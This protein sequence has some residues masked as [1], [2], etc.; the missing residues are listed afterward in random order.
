MK[1]LKMTRLAAYFAVALGVAACGADGGTGGSGG[2][3]GGGTSGS[4]IL[5]PTQDIVSDLLTN[6]GGAL[7]DTPLGPF[8]QCLDPTLNELLD[9]PDGLLT[10]L[11]SGIAGAD[12]AKLQAALTSGATDL[13][14]AIQSLTVNLPNA[15]LALAGEASCEQYT[16]G[17]G[18]TGGGGSGGGSGP[19]GTPLDQLIALL[20][21]G[22]GEGSPLDGTPLQALIDALQGAGGGSSDG[23]T[24]TPLDIILGPLLGL[25]QGGTGGGLPSIPGLPDGASQSELLD[26]LGQGLSQVGTA[27]ADATGDATADIPVIGP[28]FAT[29]STTVTDLGTVVDAIESGATSAQLEGTLTHLL[30][31][32]NGLLTGPSGLIGALAGAAGQ[33][34][35]IAGINEQINSGISDGLGALGDALLDP[36]VGEGGLVP[37]LAD[38]L[39]DVTCALFLFG[40]CKA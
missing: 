38:A 9:G 32:V 19:T 2:G 17:T 8:I 21:G 29:L 24:G 36:L 14:T 34:D 28:L 33:A 1:K 25:A 12:P 11:L 40:N 7:G 15:L 3:G 22:T 26:L 4:T 18:G 27:L 10:S 6:L 35:A 16:P 20:Q 39:K 31:N 5:N 30:Q 13:A 37:T 23:P